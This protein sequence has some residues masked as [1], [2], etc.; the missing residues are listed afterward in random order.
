[1]LRQLFDGLSPRDSLLRVALLARD[2][3]ATL[4]ARDSIKHELRFI[5][6]LPEPLLEQSLRARKFA[7]VSKGA[8]QRTRG[9][10]PDG[11]FR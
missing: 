10:R 11:S 8:R 6:K 4:E 3:A 9:L 5:R 1:M 7:R 2:L